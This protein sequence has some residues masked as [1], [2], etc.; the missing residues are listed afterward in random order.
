MINKTNLYFSKVAKN[1]S[2]SSSLG[3]WN[4]LRKY[5][6]K[7]ILEFLENKKFK[8]I[9]ELGS[10]SGFYTYILNEY[11]KNKIT[12]VD[13][14]QTMLDQINLIN[15]RKINS[16]IEEFVEKKHYDLIFCAGALEFVQDPFKVFINAK[17]M[18]GNDG[19]FVI[20]VPR[21]NLFGILYKCF[22]Y[23]NGIKIN[24]FTKKIILKYA[25]SSG[26]KVTKMTKVSLFSACYSF[27]IKE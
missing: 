20:L 5:E 6:K 24:L 14:S 7:T 19:L 16:N 17:N 11:T 22:H 27:K 4:I 25:L 8:K 21:K 23:S 2:K 12:C 13:F 9:L 15:I 3:L 10:G 26:F 18:I 1:Y